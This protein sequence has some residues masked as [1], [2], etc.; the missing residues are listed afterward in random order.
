[1][2]TRKTALYDVHQQ[3]GA[4]LVEFAGYYMPIQYRGIIEEHRRVR[5]TVGLF[6]V[7]HMGVLEVSGPDAARLRAAE[8]LLEVPGAVFAGQ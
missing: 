3:A 1:M 7:T 5:T 2:E 6:D 8:R 4:K